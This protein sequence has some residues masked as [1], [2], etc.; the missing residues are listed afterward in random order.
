MRI[1]T[2]LVGF[3]SLTWVRGNIS[4]IF[5]VEQDQARLVLV[6]HQ[7]QV[8]QTLWPKD[9]GMSDK[10]IQEE[11]SISLNS[12]INSQ[13]LIDAS[14]LS[15]KR[16]QSG[17]WN[18]KHDRNEKIGEWET[19]VWNVESLSISSETRREH[20]SA[21]PLPSEKLYPR[22]TP[23]LAVVNPDQES[24]ESDLEAELEEYKYG[25]RNVDDVG[26]DYQESA[27]KAK[28]AFRKL[29]Q[30]RGSLNPPPL[31][32]ISLQDF[33]S[34]NE[35]LH[36]GRPLELDKQVKSLKAT[37][38]MNDSSDVNFPIKVSSLL[39]LL[40]LIGMGSQT[41]VQTLLE[42]FNFKL[43]PGFPV[44]VEIPMDLLPLSATI[45]FNNVSTS[46]EMESYLFSIPSL[47]DGFI[48]GNVI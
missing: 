30:F 9:F 36:L 39:P 44:Q 41:H 1:D 35:S 21:Y 12:P 20:L 10:E 11:I 43:P 33:L 45:T 40:Q 17:F 37:L 7:R 31:H 42:F 5:N 8:V 14:L 4:F 26:D 29:A 16:A 25:Y 15:I 24:D 28:K 6:D 38:W 2:T 13:P 19:S 46:R 34:G 3:E 48:E 32:P 22:Q 27:K 47:K 18:F 23:T